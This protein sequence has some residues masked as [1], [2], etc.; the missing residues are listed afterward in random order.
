MVAEKY[1]TV[2]KFCRYFVGFTIYVFYRLC[3]LCIGVCGVIINNLIIGNHHSTGTGNSAQKG[4]ILW[5]WKHYEMDYT[6]QSDF[7]CFFNSRVKPDSVLRPNVSLYALTDKEAFFVETAENVNIYSSKVHPFFFVAQFKYARN[8]I[9]MSITDFVSLAEMIGDPTVP[10]IWISNTGRCG[11]TMLCEVLESV[12]ETLLIHESDP[13]LHLWRLQDKGK[14]NATQYDAILRSIIRILGKPHHGTQ[15][16][17]I[18]PRPQCTVMMKDITRLLPNIR[19]IFMYRNPLNT[20]ISLVGMM[21]SEPFPIVLCSCADSEWFSKICPYFRH[22]Q[23][24]NFVSKPKDFQDVPADANTAGVFAYLWSYMIIIA[25]EALTRD[26]KILPVKY[27]DIIARPKEAV[28]QLFDSLEI[29]YIHVDNALTS[30]ER[31]SQRDSV[32]N[33]DKL[34]SNKNSISTADRIKIDSILSK[35]DL[36]LWDRDF[37]I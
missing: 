29:D 15:R 16:I 18:K 9:K 22:L 31:D 23:R 6:S 30:M 24:Y 35:F 27:E 13:P 10:V 26:P 8:V 20:I 34:A 33:R 14:F 21:Y 12:P 28:C 4:Q 19:Q 36:Q 3:C 37:R 7:L 11:G 25:R 2:I 17:C 1:E 32:L 5:K